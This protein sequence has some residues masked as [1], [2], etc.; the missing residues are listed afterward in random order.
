M[1]RMEPAIT[2]NVVVMIIG[3]I[4]V[5]FK[6]DLAQQMN[7]IICREVIMVGGLSDA[8]DSPR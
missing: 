3:F 2:L 5:R 8:L 6:L 7:K 1:T 4:L